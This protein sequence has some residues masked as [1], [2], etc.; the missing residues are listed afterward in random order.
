M[1]DSEVFAFSPQ[2][3]D[4]IVDLDIT[5]ESYMYP[6][7]TPVYI[8]IN[9]TGNFNAILNY[10]IYLNEKFLDSCIKYSESSNYPSVNFFLEPNKSYTIKVDSS[11]CPENFAGS[12]TLETKLTSDEKLTDLSKMFYFEFFSKQRY[13]EIQR[14]INFENI[15][16]AL[17]VD[18][19]NQRFVLSD[20]FGEIDIPYE[21]DGDIK[22]TE[23]KNHSFQID[24]MASNDAWLI[25]KDSEMSIIFPQS[26]GLSGASA[27]SDVGQIEYEKIESAQIVKLHIFKDKPVSYEFFGSFELNP[28]KSDYDR[29]FPINTQLK[30]HVKNTDILCK[31][32]LELAL[33]P[34]SHQPIC[35][36][37]KTFEKLIE[38]GWMDMLYPDNL[39][40]LDKIFFLKGTDH[41]IRY[42]ISGSE[43]T[44]IQSIVKNILVISTIESSKGNLTI[45]LPR[46][47]IASNAECS[48]DVRF[49]EKFFILANGEQTHYSEVRKNYD[50][51]ILSI[52][53]EEK[54]SEV[55]IIGSHWCKNHE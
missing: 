41:A 44:N 23:H 33:K 3:K 12:Y 22:I 6:V 27:K 52:P 21:I 28:Q 34:S 50:H 51:R 19:R 48:N 10:E 54:I 16:T 38:R 36:T 8:T 45:E 30:N 37:P 13:D 20:H 39:A 31:D 35:V 26:L 18:E 1:S 17:T 55:E 7:G 46:T 53:L 29:V 43:I 4:T 9:N 5:S 40:Y 42:S 47:L 49:D 24:V 14:E 11:N 15:K 32:D 2:D 25:S